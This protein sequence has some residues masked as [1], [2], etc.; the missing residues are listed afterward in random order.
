[1]QQVPACMVHRK[2]RRP[3][4]GEYSDIVVAS[5]ECIQ[6]VCP[7]V[8]WVT[9]TMLFKCSQI[10]NVASCCQLK[11]V[12]ELKGGRLHSDSVVQNLSTKFSGLCSTGWAGC[13]A[14]RDMMTRVHALSDPLDSHERKRKGSERG[15]WRKGAS[16]KANVK[17]DYE[18]KHSESD[19]KDHA[20]ER[21]PRTERLREL[22][23]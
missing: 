17:A 14:T 8:D 3:G 9:T 13:G 10:G 18:D 1:M 5:N 23:E 22:H 21:P 16:L 2:H 15:Y 6:K 11:G 7:V 19:Y 12:V 4:N 20:Q